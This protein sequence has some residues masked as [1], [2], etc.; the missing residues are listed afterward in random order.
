MLPKIRLWPFYPWPSKEMPQ[1]SSC[2]KVCVLWDGGSVRPSPNRSTAMGKV[3]PLFV[4]HVYKTHRS[5]SIWEEFAV[6]DLP[7]CTCAHRKVCTTLV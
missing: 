3:L 6:K 4:L 7:V 1:H 2:K 5:R